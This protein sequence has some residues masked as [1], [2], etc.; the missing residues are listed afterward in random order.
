[1]G[2]FNRSKMVGGQ[3]ISSVP[4]GFII[5]SKLRETRGTRGTILQKPTESYEDPRGTAAQTIR[6][7]T[8][9]TTQTFQIWKEGAGHGIPTSSA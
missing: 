3:S 7:H 4:E 5:I 9:H 1:M 2:V 8:T 6:V